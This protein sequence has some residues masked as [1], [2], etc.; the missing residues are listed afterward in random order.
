MYLTNYIKH[1]CESPTTLCCSWLWRSKRWSGLCFLLL[2]SSRVVA[3]LV[4][5]AAVARMQSSGRRRKKEV[6]FFS[7]WVFCRN[8][9]EKDDHKKKQ[10]HTKRKNRGS[11]AS[12]FISCVGRLHL[13]QTLTAA[14]ENNEHYASNLISCESAK[15]LRFS[16]TRE[17]LKPTWEEQIWETTWK[18][19]TRK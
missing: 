3:W 13:R 4:A 18:K 1:L 15:V 16:K 2:V 8:E 9:K 7:W 19:F 14:F 11:G 6:L 10:N 5:A 17:L 12:K